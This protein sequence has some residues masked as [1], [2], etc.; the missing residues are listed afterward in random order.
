MRSKRSQDQARSQLSFGLCC[1]TIGGL[2]NARPLFWYSSSISGKLSRKHCFAQNKC[3]ALPCFQTTGRFNSDPCVTL[4]AEGHSAGL[5]RPSCCF[6]GKMPLPDGSAE[7]PWTYQPLAPD[8]VRWYWATGPLS[9]K[10]ERLCTSTQV[11]YSSGSLTLLR[12]CSMVQGRYPQQRLIPTLLS[13]R[14]AF[15]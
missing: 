8:E 9:L 13:Y 3:Q 1:A 15:T 10:G 14:L 6:L 4:P 11:T 12:T 5:Q 2:C 7:R